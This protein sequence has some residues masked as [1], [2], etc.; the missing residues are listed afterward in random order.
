MIFNMCGLLVANGLLSS[1]DAKIWPFCAFHF[2]ISIILQDT[3]YY[4][5]SSLAN[6]FMSEIQ[7][8]YPN[9]YLCGGPKM[10]PRTSI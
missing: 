4:I 10:S 7:K 5:I 6:K 1:Q 2:K 3:S 9:S 8:Q